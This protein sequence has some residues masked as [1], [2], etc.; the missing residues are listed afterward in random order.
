MGEVAIYVDD[1][2]E[3]ED[4]LELPSSSSSSSGGGGV[5]MSSIRLCRIC[6]EADDDEEEFIT[7]PAAGTSSPIININ[8]NKP[9]PAPMESPCSCSGTIKFAHREC[10]QRWCNEKGN[11]VCELCSRE[12]EPGY[13]APK[14]VG[15]TTTTVTFRGSLEVP[16]SSEDGVDEEEE[17]HNTICSPPPADDDHQRSSSSCRCT[18]LALIITLLL[19]VRNVYELVVD[20]EEEYYDPPFSIPTVLILKASG[21]FI[22]MFV[23]S[24]ILHLILDTVRNYR[25]NHPQHSYYYQPQHQDY[26]TR[27]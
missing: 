27:Q 17:D 6:H 12:Y 16:I 14:L 10:I 19:L 24:R 13:T 8:I 26:I 2:Y 23:L 18:S 9:R 11:T 15:A 4:Q 7:T 3:Y 22:P 1:D 21:I 25:H 20:Q 5:K